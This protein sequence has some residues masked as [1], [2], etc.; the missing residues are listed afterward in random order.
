VLVIME[1][2]SQMNSVLFNQPFLLLLPLVILNQYFLSV[3]F[4]SDLISLSKFFSVFLI[5]Q[6]VLF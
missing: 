2:W 4:L 3:F 6:K 5:N 1:M